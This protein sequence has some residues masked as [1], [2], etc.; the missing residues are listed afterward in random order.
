MITICNLMPIE[1]KWV[2]YFWVRQKTFSAAYT[3]KTGLQTFHAKLPDAYPLAIAKM[4]EIRCSDE[5]Y[6]NH[7]YRKF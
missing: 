7:P 3:D 5:E 6:K 2:Q 4:V 1:P